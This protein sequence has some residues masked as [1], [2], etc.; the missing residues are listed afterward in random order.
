MRKFAKTCVRKKNIFFYI[1]NI[2]IF[3][4]KRPEGRRPG[5]MG[6]L[7]TLVGTGATLPYRVQGCSLL[8]SSRNIFGEVKGNVVVCRVSRTKRGGSVLRDVEPFIRVAGE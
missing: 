2:Y 5:K 3:K 7:L 4:I 6:I 8:S 1:Y